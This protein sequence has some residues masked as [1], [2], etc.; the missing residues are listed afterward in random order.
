VGVLASICIT[1]SFDVCIAYYQV[2]HG[3]ECP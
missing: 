1:L 2:A 3:G